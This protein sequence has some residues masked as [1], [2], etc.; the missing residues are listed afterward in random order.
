MGERPRRSADAGSGASRPRKGGRRRASGRLAAADRRRQ[1]LE[2]AAEIFARDGFVGARI[3]DITLACGVTEATLYRHFPS[4][5]ALFEQTLEARLAADDAGDFLRGLD[6][7]API[8]ET[9]RTIALRILR[10]GWEDPTLHRLLLAASLAGRTG[11]QGA[12]VRWRVPYIEFL[13]KLI[14][15]G[16]ARG[17]LRETDPVLTARAFVGLVMDCVLSCR[18]WSEVGNG[19]ADPDALVL[20]NVPTFVRGLLKDPEGPRDAATTPGGD[21]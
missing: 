1:I 13:E 3:R 16:T 7:N 4:K 9:F 12:Y 11:T 8:E 10:T 5:E 19:E 20:N 14:R 2:Q 15:D 6:R 17:D 18:L 21:S